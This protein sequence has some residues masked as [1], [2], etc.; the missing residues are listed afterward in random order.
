MY[1]PRQYLSIDPKSFPRPLE[2]PQIAHKPQN[3]VNMNVDI[4]ETIKDRELDL[5]FGF[6]S[7]AHSA[8]LLCEYATPTLTPTIRP[9]LWRPQFS[10]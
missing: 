4:S 6:R 3:I 1:Y 10:C 7:F 8:S 9:N 2:R 5:R